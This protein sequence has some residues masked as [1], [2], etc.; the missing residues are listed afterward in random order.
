MK[1]VAVFCGSREGTN[2]L[3]M[4]EAKKLGEQLA[5][6]NIELVYGG[7]V[8][9]LMGVVASGVI[10]NGGTVT[11]VI[12]ER[13]KMIEIAHKGLNQLHVVKDMH[14]RKA[15]MAKLSDAFIAL[16]GG[17]GTLEEWFEVF[18]WAQIGYH[19]KPC[20][21]LNTNDYYTPLVNLFDHMITEGFADPHYKENVIVEDNVNDLIKCLTT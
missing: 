12:P 14:E 15:M 10:E 17:V 3:Y 1:R 13:L 21:L 4:Q 2:E 19:Q 16:P 5:K 18:T 20:A 7:A 8:V 6:H 11:G 9:G